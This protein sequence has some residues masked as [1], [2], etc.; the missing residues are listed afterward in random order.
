LDDDVS[1]A[2][3]Y[4]PQR[5]SQGPMSTLSVVTYRNKNKRQFINQYKVV[6]QLGTGAYATVKLCID[7]NNHESFAIKIMNKG[8]LKKI[9]TGKHKNAYD[10]VM[11][12]LKVMER[13]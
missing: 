1:D 6:K 10:C 3:S 8:R 4:R 12:E 2:T 5:R 7:K 13:L 11:D 9:R